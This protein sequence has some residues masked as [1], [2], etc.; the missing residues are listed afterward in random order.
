MREGARPFPAPRQ[1]K[2]ERGAASSA[3]S[4]TRRFGQLW[5]R[6]REDKHFQ[7]VEQRLWIVVTLVY[8]RWRGTALEQDVDRL[9][10]RANG[11]FDGEGNLSR[12]LDVLADQSE[13]RRPLRNSGRPVAA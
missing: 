10:R 9:P 4:A 8:R 13:I 11:A 1:W 6:S 3:E 12:N 5:R 2:S 7:R